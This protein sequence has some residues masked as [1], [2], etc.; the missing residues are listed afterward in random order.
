M[1]NANLFKGTNV[2]V[3]QKLCLKD[4]LKEK[5]LLLARYRLLGIG[6]DRALFRVRDLKWFYRGSLVDISDLD[7]FRESITAEN[8]LDTKSQGRESK[9]LMFPKCVSSTLLA[10]QLSINAVVLD[11][12]LLRTIELLFLTET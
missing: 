3:Q 8:S 2:F 1:S 6:A 5:E 10:Q 12:S 11:Y 4:R 7:R 9:R